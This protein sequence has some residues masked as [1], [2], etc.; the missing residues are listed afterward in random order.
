MSLSEGSIFYGNN[1]IQ[2]SVSYVE[3]KTLEISVHP[4]ADVVVRAPSGADFGEI[5]K[6]IFRRAKWITKQQGYFRQFNPR[7]PARQYIS[8]ETHLYLGKQ[9]RLKIEESNFYTVKLTRGFFQVQVKPEDSPDKIKKVLNQW[10]YEKAALKMKELTDECWRYFEGVDF[11]KPE[12]QIRK[13]K[14]RWGSLSKRETLT[15]NIDLIRAP[16]ECI[17]YVIIHELC[18]LKY[19]D[20]SA[21]FYHLLE[22]IM[23]NWK[24]FKHKLEVQMA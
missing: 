15:L 5:R 11:E 7:T 22:K 23:P 1:E 12:L 16:K 19:N 21:E 9:Y 4:N 3:R 24:N 14:T 8:G 17:E 10:Y 2:F 18:H 6:I 20:H 13:M